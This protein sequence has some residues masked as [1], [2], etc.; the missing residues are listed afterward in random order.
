MRPT[1]ALSVR[2]PYAK[3]IIDGAPIFVAVDNENGTQSVEYSGKVIVKNI[4][5]RSRPLPV[6]MVGQRVMIHAGLQFA[7]DSLE[8]LMESRLVGVMTAL[9][10][11]TNDNKIIPRGAIVGEVTLTGCVTESDNP[12]FTGPYGWTL[13]NPIAYPE[14]IPWKGKLGFFEV[15]LPQEA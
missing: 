1:R 14:P 13:E 10:L 3:L 7:P 6:N 15:A 5:N 9:M 11:H 4:E 8:W 12:W 2:Q